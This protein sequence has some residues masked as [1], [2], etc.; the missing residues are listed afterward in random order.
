MQLRTFL[1][2]SAA[3]LLVGAALPAAASTSVITSA[4]AGSTFV[5]FP[6][7]NYFGPGPQTFGGDITWSSTN[8]STQGGSVF[9][10]NGGYGF[11][12]NGFS[13]DNLVGLNDSSHV[14]G[15]S[16][17]SME[18]DFSTAVSAV[19]GVLNWVPD[20]GDTVT[21]S[22]FDAG[23]NLLGSLQLAAGG[24]NSVTPDS[25]YGFQSSTADISRFVLT[26][27]YVAVLDG[28]SVGGGGAVPE[29]ATW[30]LSILGF[31]GAGS[32]LRRR[33]TVAVAA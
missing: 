22:A 15:I 30:A 8:A 11:D 32:M 3:V 6:V 27:G 23:N 2:A 10:Y 17:D 4:P 19:G 20:N 1:A 26:D 21:I 14:Y 24:A 16:P 7:L 29:P 5:A 31:F 33:R 9:G 13:S 12:S 28:L 18:F 25:F